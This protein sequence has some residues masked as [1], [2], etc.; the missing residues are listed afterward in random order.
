MLAF[1]LWKI[2]IAPRAFNAAAGAPPVPH[3]VF[4]RLDGDRFQ[5]AG[6]R[7]RVLFLDFF[8]T[9]CTPCRIELPLVESWAKSHRNALVVPVDVAEPRVVAAAFASAHQLTNVALDPNG[10]SRGIFGIDGFPTVVVV[11]PQGRIRA[12]WQGLN[13]AIALAMSNAEKTL[14]R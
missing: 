6:A 10:D 5:V 8:A 11:D 9:W 13:P 14:A 7:G 4:A 2:F 3:A 12:K 1:A